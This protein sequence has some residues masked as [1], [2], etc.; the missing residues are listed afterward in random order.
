MTGISLDLLTVILLVILA[1]TWGINAGKK[2]EKEEVMKSINRAI[3]SFT[4][5]ITKT[6][7]TTRVQ[8]P[9]KKEEFWTLMV[10]RM[11]NEKKGDSD[12]Q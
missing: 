8:N 4:S 6:E 9:D 11:K 3:A 10:D 2:M 5:S 1:F 12:Q 7:S